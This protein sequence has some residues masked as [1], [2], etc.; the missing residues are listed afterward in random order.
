MN[1]SV[2]NRHRSYRVNGAL[3]CRFARRALKRLGKAAGAELSVVFL[4]DRAM[5]ALNRRYKKH[6]RPTDVLSFPLDGGDGAA[7]EGI[8]GAIA[9]SLDRAKAQAKRFHA[10]FGEEAVRYVVHGILHLSGYDDLARPD[11]ALMSTKED[12]ILRWLATRERLSKVLT[13]R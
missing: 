7:V 1:V 2:E 10:G 12:E 4:D 9:V 11:R 3:V 6:D 13:P 8:R 5:R